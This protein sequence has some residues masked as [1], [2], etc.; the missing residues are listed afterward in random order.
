MAERHVAFNSGGMKLYG[1]LHL[2][3]SK[4]KVPCVILSHGFGSDKSS[5][6]LF[7]RVG[8]VFAENGIA[9]LRFDNRG[10][11]DSEGSYKNYNMSAKLDDMKEAVKFAKEEKEIDSSKIGLAGISY[12][13][14]ASVIFAARAKDESLKCVDAWAPGILSEG[15]GPALIEEA[16]RRGIVK[17]HYGRLYK[18]Q[19]EDDAKYKLYNESRKIRI[20]LQVIHGDMDTTVPLAE[21]EQVFENAKGPK[22]LKII[23]GADHGFNYHRKD[24]IESSLKWFKKWFF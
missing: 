12:G 9:T 8:R 4:K 5:Y 19:L 11:G 6:R 20:P 24:L 16:K 23:K 22:N 1:V 2:P 7:V 21:G 18:E 17:F 14:S 13:G 15:V 10:C 3:L